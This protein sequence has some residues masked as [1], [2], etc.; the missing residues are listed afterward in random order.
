[1]AG[2]TNVAWSTTTPVRSAAG[3]CLYGHHF[4]T[5]PL[6]SPPSGL[7]Y[8]HAI[9]CSVEHPYIMQ[10]SGILGAAMHAGRI[11]GSDRSA[12]AGTGL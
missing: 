2:L 4:D 5:L 8:L 6:S 7:S 10:W 3:T 12:P 9:G 11:P 1:M